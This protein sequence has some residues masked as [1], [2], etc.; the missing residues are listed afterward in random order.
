MTL[1]VFGRREGQ[2]GA[3]I[4]VSLLIH[5]VAL[6]WLPGLPRAVEQ[7]GE[8]LPPLQIR[9]STPAVRPEPVAVAPAP[10]LEPTPVSSRREAAPQHHA[11]P[12]LATATPQAAVETT[13]L[14]VAE[15]VAAVATDVPR[16]IALPSPARPSAPDA[17]VLAAYGR[18][19]AGAVAAHQRYPRVA[20]LRQWQGTSVLQL[21][22]A[23]DGRLLGVRV[24][25]SSGHDTLDRQALEMVRE[26]VPLPSMPAVLAGRPLT[27]D[28]PVVFRIA[29]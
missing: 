6:G 10:T 4:A 18:D 3:A 29:S 17:G 22:L 24:L 5:G 2:I 28:V 23:A 8:S 26:A 13:T 9:L 20:L 15:P 12:V 19:L 21:E 27:V 7:V 1:P 11:T 25:S 14:R 16:P